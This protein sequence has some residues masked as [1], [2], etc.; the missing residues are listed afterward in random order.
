MGIV[1]PE[2]IVLRSGKVLK[3]TYTYLPVN[4]MCYVEF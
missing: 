1:G 2:E 4:P 3:Y